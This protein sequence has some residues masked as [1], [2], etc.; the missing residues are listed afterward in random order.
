ML[1]NL[2]KVL[3]F[4][5][6]LKKPRVILLVDDFA[7]VRMCVLG[8]TCWK[9]PHLLFCFSC[10]ISERKKSQISFGHMNEADSSF[11]V[12]AQPTCFCADKSHLY[13][14]LVYF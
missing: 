7:I 13:P 2:A 1:F 12:T 5:G 6:A 10:L 11:N 9:L 14:L 3:L 8:Y 4:W